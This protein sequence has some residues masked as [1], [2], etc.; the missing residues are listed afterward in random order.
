MLN[1]IAA[2]LKSSGAK[3]VKVEGHTDPLGS[4]KY[5]LVLS[6]HR[7]DIVRDY[8]VSQGVEANFETVGVGEANQVKACK[9]HGKELKDCLRP[10]RRVVISADGVTQSVEAGPIG[11]TPLYEK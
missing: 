8:L 5:N 11:P 10:N 2:T 3:T 9:G 1:N 7:A 4:E 6:Q